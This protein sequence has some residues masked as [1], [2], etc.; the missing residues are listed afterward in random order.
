MQPFRLFFTLLPFLLTAQESGTLFS[1]DYRL[2]SAVI[3]AFSDTEFVSA[4]PTVRITVHLSDT[5]AHVPALIYGN[6]ANVYMTQ[7]VNN[8]ELVEHIR[9]LSPNILRYPGGNLSQMFFWDAEPGEL[10][11]DVPAQLPWTIEGSLREQYRFGRNQDEETLSIDNYY[12]MLEMTGSQGL[13]TVNY[14]YARYG[15][16]QD[17]V[18]RAAHYA[19]DWVRYDHGRT[20]FWEIGNENYGEW[21]AGYII[22]TLTNR[23]GQPEI[24]SGALYGKHFKV[25][26]DSMRRAAGESGSEIAIGC[27]LI[28]TAQDWRPA[29][30]KY[31]NEGFFRAAGNAADYFVVHSYFTPWQ[32]NSPVSTILNSASVE[33]AA[34]REF[35]IHACIENQAALKPLALTEWNIFAIGSKQQV[36]A[37]NGM[38]AVLVLGELIKHRFALA[39]RW[40]LANGWAN[41]NDHGMFS[42]GGEPGVPRFHPRPVFYYMTLFQRMF[43][44]QMVDTSVPDS[45]KV[46]AYASLFHSGESGIV[47]VNKGQEIQIVRLT[48]EGRQSSG[49]RCTWY[50]LTGGKDNPPFSRKVVINGF[51]SVLPAGGPDLGEVK[52]CSSLIDD[53]VTLLLPS[54]GTQFIL[55]E[56]ER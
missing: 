44:D 34:I 16:S 5:L 55:I 47:L 29:V 4:D 15:S 46:T 9:E 53:E 37:V 45:S 51:E 39:C 35:I 6:N 49:S 2:K 27:L 11:Q 25:F 19:A 20:K 30:Q 24:I 21:Q 7:M 50:T 18:A 17:P 22:D 41:G 43:G 40:N 3:P 33:V 14:A 38:H 23:D 56:F 8:P 26:A 1:E 36:S 32:E 10:P 31:W 54:Y 28:E 52:A 42:Q 13:I 48:L 12:R